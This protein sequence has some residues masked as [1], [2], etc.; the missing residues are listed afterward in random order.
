MQLYVNLTA[1]VSLISTWILSLAP[2]LM[3]WWCLTLRNLL[4]RNASGI[5][6]EVV[7]CRESRLLQSETKQGRART[8]ITKGYYEKRCLRCAT[9]H[10]CADRAN[11]RY[12]LASAAITLKLTRFVDC[13]QNTPKSCSIKDV[14]GY[15]ST[16]ETMHL[17]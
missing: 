2:A 17:L 16:T 6:R 11:S 5:L 10:C 8:F 9:G 15:Q 13:F 12:F 4:S 1:C 14:F 7:F 3:A